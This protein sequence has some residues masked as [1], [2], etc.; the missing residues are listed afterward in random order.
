M[1][2][3]NKL[4]QDVNYDKTKILA[5][6]VITTDPA[7]VIKDTHWILMGA[8]KVMTYPATKIWKDAHKDVQVVFRFPD[9]TVFE[10]PSSS[11][12]SAWNDIEQMDVRFIR[13]S[14]KEIID[15]DVAATMGL[16][17]MVIR[18]IIVPGNPFEASV[19]IA[20]APLSKDGLVDTVNLADINDY[21]IP[22]I[23]IHVE[24]AEDEAP[25]TFSTGKA[26]TMMR[27]EE[28]GLGLGMGI[29]P[30]LDI[31]SSDNEDQGIPEPN[32]Y[33][34]ASMKFLRK[35]AVGYPTTAHK[36]ESMMQRYL[37]NTLPTMKKAPMIFPEFVATVARAI[38][39]I[40]KGSS[41]IL[42]ITCE[43]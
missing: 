40:C 13:K 41:L 11:N 29:L 42:T 16:G 9:L 35:V 25:N 1:A 2:L 19:W 17:D 3:V 15:G 18:A 31:A 32:K 26:V 12:M 39:R 43:L 27:Q 33:K 14:T 5:T 10:F 24:E 23:P 34:E 8:F 22:Y 4:V 7:G 30:F 37:G 6:A 36:F 28:P 38:G 21:S 20:V